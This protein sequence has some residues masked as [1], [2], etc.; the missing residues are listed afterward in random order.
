MV[1]RGYYLKE[2]LKLEKVI[3]AVVGYGGMG[4]YHLRDIVKNEP[5]IQYVGG[6][7][8]N[9]KRQVALEENGYHAYQSY[10]E[11]LADEKINLVLV[12]TPNDVH[13]ELV[14]RALEAGKNVLVEKPAMMSSK[15]MEEVMAV[16]EKTG[17]H[18]FVHQNRRWDPDFRMLTTLYEE[19]PIGEVFQIESRV[20]GAN[21]I[22]GDWR[23]YK[24]QGGGM[25][26]DWGVHL[27]DQLLYM[28]KS[29]VTA[30]QTDLSYVLGNDVDDGFRT[31]LY[32]ENGVQALVEV[33]TT[34]FIKLPRWYVK[35]SKGTAEIT[36]WDLSG[37]MVRATG[38]D[39][40]APAPVQ[41][42]VGLTK[43]MA[44][45]SERAVENMPLPKTTDL[46][47]TFYEN[48]AQVI[49]NDATPIVK[50]D[51]VLRV[52][53]LMEKVFEAGEKHQ[54]LPFEK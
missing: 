44:P 21:G 6:Y 27:F 48:I 2:I 22:P 31:V 52:L 19:K 18:F 5:H 41:A 24:K 54:I 40:T 11:L 26:L 35:A 12:A 29:P 53:H 50:N 28:I 15:E 36:D 7:D 47:V 4:S 38:Y 3:A 33:G 32:F 39:E 9:E 34:N 1:D 10:D 46:P 16:A 30:V 23:H 45:P 17:R 8:I 43:T 13:K 25:V 37:K 42:G 20:H 49:L 14:I 51:E